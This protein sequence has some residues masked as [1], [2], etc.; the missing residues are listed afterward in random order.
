[1]KMASNRAEYGFDA[2]GVMK[3]LL[4][5]GLGGSVIGAVVASLSSGWLQVA[6][7]L[8]V[9]ISV[10]PLLLGFSMV[11][12]GLIGKHRMRDLMLSLIDWQGEERVLDIGT[13]RGLLLIGAAKRL[14]R[15]GTATGIDIWRAE[16]LTDNTLDR[17]AEN[18]GAEGVD[19]RV[20]LITEDAR[21]LSFPDASFDVVLSL[22]CI[23]NIDDKQQQ[24]AA[25][26]EIVRV[27]KP[28]GRALIGEYLPTHRYADVF[29]AA[30]MTVHA[31]RT[32]LATALTLMWM[33]DAQKPMTTHLSLDALPERMPANG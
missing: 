30:G 11:V 27:L 2:P 29:R 32:H 17:L 19:G 13:G 33:V 20:A 3:G 10:V 22:Y 24:T 4:A 26:L 21:K 23:H 31:S 25:L 18:V 6:A 12:Y 15:G 5:A 1:M 16:D 14:D 28:G 7:L 9:G 8:F